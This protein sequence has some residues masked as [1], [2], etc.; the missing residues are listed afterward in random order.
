MATK[1][2]PDSVDLKLSNYS[3]TAAMN[4][5]IASANNATLATAPPPP[6]RSPPAQCQGLKQ[7]ATPPKSMYKRAPPSPPPQARYKAAPPV[8]HL[9]QTGPPPATIG[10][11]LARL[12]KRQG[13]RNTLDISAKEWLL[14]VISKIYRSHYPIEFRIVSYCQPQD[15]RESTLRAAGN[16]SN[17]RNNSSTRPQSRYAT[18]PCRTPVGEEPDPSRDMSVA[19]FVAGSALQR[20]HQASL[21]ADCSS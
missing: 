16:F 5:S 1:S 12:S 19:A 14:K 7:P 4:G 8:K 3:T 18:P 13:R 10:I 17:V 6:L 9:R 15:T 11:S 2:T 20:A 21:I